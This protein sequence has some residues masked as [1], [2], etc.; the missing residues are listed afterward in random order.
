[1]RWEEIHLERREW[2]IPDTK[3]GD[4]LRVHLVDTVLD[5]LQSRL[6]RYGKKEWVFEGPG[7]TGHLMEPKAGWKR[8]LDRASL[9]DLRDRKS[10]V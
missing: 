5:V 1:M 4:P 7:V 2:L 8:I 9:K 3:N 6:E 10:V